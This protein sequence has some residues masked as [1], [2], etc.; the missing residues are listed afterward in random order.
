VSVDLSNMPVGARLITR[1]GRRARLIAKDLAGPCPY[2]VAVLR[3]GGAESVGSVDAAGRFWRDGGASK[4]D[5][6]GRGAL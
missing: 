4:F 6:V 1:E 5:I 2:A 3:D